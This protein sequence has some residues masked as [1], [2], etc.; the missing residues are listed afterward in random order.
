MEGESCVLGFSMT[1]SEW[2][3][4]EGGNHQLTR[5]VS[6]ETRKQKT[7][8]NTLQLQYILCDES[9]F[10]LYMYVYVHVY[11]CTMAVKSDQSDCS[12]GGLYTYTHVHSSVYVFT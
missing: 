1:V 7:E 10:H 3:E 6:I 12:I 8:S 2:E 11:I 4:R 9:L 5:Q